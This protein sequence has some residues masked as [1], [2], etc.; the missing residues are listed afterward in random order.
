[1]AEE[2]DDD[3]PEPAEHARFRAYQRAL[4]DV[5]EVGEVDLLRTV[6]A[7]PDKAMAESAVGR[8]LDLRASALDDG[9][10]FARWARRVAPALEG[11]AF[12]SRRLHEWSL[13]KDLSAGR[14]VGAQALLDASDWLQRLLAAG[15][16]DPSVLALLAARGR[17]RR[18]RAASGRRLDLP[19]H[20][21]RPG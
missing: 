2:E 12:P 9:D 7:D 16:D 1:M 3:G 21:R 20:P 11:H 8:H 10:G 14:E 18:V 4:A 6:L 5:G 17:T 13:W 15:S 19:R